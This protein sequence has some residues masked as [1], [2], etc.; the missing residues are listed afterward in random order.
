MSEKGEKGEKLVIHGNYAAAYG[1]K[2]ARAQVV[3]AY[4]ITP[5]TSIV[6]KIADFIAAGE[7]KAKYIMVES[8]HSAM[9]ACIAAE[10]TGVRTFTATS[11]NG[12]LLMHEMLT[13]A[14]AARLPIVLVNVNRALAPPWSVWAEATDSIAQRDTGWM[15]FYCESSQ[16]ILDTVIMA[17]KIGE[18]SNILLPALIN[19]DAFYLSHTVE[20]VDIPAQNLVDEFLPTYNPE[21]KIDVNR[22]MGFGSLSMPHQWYPELRLKVALAM[23]DA[24]KAIREVTKEF[25]QKFGRDYGGL[26]ESYRADD[27][28]YLIA[29]YGTIASTARE[30]VDSLRNRGI[31]AGLV[32]MRVLRPF[33]VEDLRELLNKNHAKYLAVLDRAYTFGYE[34]PFFTE[35]KGALYG[36]RQQ[37]VIKNYAIGIGGRD[38]TQADIEKTIL[39]GIEMLNSGKNPIESGSEI[40]W[41]NMK[42]S[43]KTGVWIDIPRR[44]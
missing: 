15:Q 10:N 37:P 4:P 34:G 20:P 16:E 21:Y 7:M 2:L 5:Q 28:E 3:A 43:G 32:K 31:K 27:A 30:A 33:P 40:T 13:W 39:D 11:A 12:L 22:P 38:V 23:E 9:A 35:I 14:A 25:A 8:E 6:E 1:A 24:K 17:Y 42:S 41:A 19:Q 44:L 26:I 29:A 36:C 18:K